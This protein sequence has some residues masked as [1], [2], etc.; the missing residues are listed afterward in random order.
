[1]MGLQ[2]EHSIEY[3]PVAVKFVTPGGRGNGNLSGPIE[4]ASRK[5]VLVRTTVFIFV[6]PMTKR[7]CSCNAYETAR[8][9]N[10]EV[11]NL[12]HYR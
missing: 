10:P 6:S 11:F 1:M 9:R 4:T 3:R 5:T 12:N 7:I 8:C 2:Y